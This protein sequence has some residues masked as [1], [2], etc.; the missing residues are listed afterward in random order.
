[1]GIFEFEPRAAAQLV[2]CRGTGASGLWDLGFRHRVAAQIS[3]CR[4]SDLSD[5]GNFQVSASC[6]GSGLLPVA[7]GISFL[8]LKASLAAFFHVFHGFERGKHNKTK[9]LENPNV[10]H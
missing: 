9:K 10:Q 6:R 5:L 1:M 4:G 2:G 3:H 8:H 7:A